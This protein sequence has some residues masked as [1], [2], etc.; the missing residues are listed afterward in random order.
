MTGTE[1]EL[2]GACTARI[3]GSGSG[4]GQPRAYHDTARTVLGTGAM[5]TAILCLL[6]L[7]F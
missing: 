2:A 5:R 3:W 1:E 7:P 6:F 4:E